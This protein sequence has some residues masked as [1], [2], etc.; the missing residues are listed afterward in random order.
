MIKCEWTEIGED[1]EIE[2]S[3]QK[4]FTNATNMLRHIREVH[5]KPK[6]YKCTHCEMSFRHKLKLKRHEIQ[7]H[8]LLH[9]FSCSTCKRGFYQKWQLEK[10]SCRTAKCYCCTQCEMKFEKWSLYIKHCKELQHGRKYHE[11]EYCKQKYSRPSELEF[12]IKLKHSI[13]QAK[14]DTNNNGIIIFS[15]PYENCTKA[16]SYEKNLKQHIKSIHEGKRY[17]CSHQDCK[18]EFTSIQNLHKHFQRDH[19]DLLNGEKMDKCSENNNIKKQDPVNKKSLKCKSKEK[20]RK[21]RK[22]AGISKISTLVTLSGLSVSK[23][24]NEQIRCRESEALEQ[25]TE[26]LKF[27]LQME[28]N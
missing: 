8:T 21:K 4:L 20:K 23:E 6:T 7:Q 16:Y 14:D 28:I 11:C 25:V 17:Q 22:D 9:P 12:H 13:E 26:S 5:E 10:H 15:C 27:C 19:H 3:C 24:M 18:R 2:S 1:G